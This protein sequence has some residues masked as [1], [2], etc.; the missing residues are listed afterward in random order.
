MP[1]GLAT[2]DMRGLASLVIFLTNLL[3]GLLLAFAS[4][5]SDL[6]WGLFA[7]SRPLAIVDIYLLRSL[8]LTTENGRVL[9]AQ[10]MP[11]WRLSAVTS[12]PL[13]LSNGRSA[14]YR[15]HHA[16][17]L[18]LDVLG[19]YFLTQVCSQRGVECAGGERIW[20]V[21]PPEPGGCSASV[22]ALGRAR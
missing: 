18:D 11:D 17:E 8:S 7:R 3:I 16:F 14:G 19:E 6:L 12:R 10:S 21:M 4:L 2:R 22:R 15:L 9:C 1:R 20:A 5:A 13:H